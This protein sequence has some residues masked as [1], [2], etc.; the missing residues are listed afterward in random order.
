M[1]VLWRKSAET[2]RRFVNDG[3]SG[4]SSKLAAADVASFKVRSL[5]KDSLKAF[6]YDAFDMVVETAW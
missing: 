2:S 6:G 4:V 3:G 1:A 5:A